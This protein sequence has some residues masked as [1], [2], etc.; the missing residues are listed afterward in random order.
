MKINLVPN[1]HQLR[2][3]YVTF[4]DREVATEVAEHLVASNIVACANI[5]A[6]HE[7][8]YLWQD[9]MENQ[10]EVAVFFKLNHA[11]LERFTSQLGERHPYDVPCVVEV[12]IS[13]AN[14]NYLAW[15]LS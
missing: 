1:Q 10:Q 11:N 14:E 15:A 7:S 3:F 2:M 5:C 13:A 9:K 6:P 4:P 12:S 8:V